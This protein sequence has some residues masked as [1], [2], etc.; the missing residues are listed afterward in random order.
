MPTDTLLARVQA[1]LEDLWSDPRAAAE[2]AE[3]PATSLAGHDLSESD[4]AN[5]NLQQ[6]AGN[7]SHSGNISSEGRGTLESFSHSHSSGHDRPVHDVAFVTREIHH[8]NPAVTNVFNDNR[9]FIDQSHDFNNSGI[10]AGDV[11][12]DDHSANAI[13]AG[14]VAGSGD[15]NVVAATGDGS[16]AAQGSTV[17][18]ADHGSQVIDGSTVGQNQSNS[19]G[20]VQ[21]GDEASGVNTGVNT[22]VV[23]GDQVD[24]TVVG[25][26]NKVA[27]VDGHADGSAIGFGQGDTSAAS[28]N[29]VRDGSLSSGGDA[30]SASHNEADHGGAIGGD[31]ALGHSLESNETNVL[32]S[33][34]TNLAQDESHATAHQD[35]HQVDHTI[36]DSVIHDAPVDA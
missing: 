4:L 12:I 35:I 14:A 13:G 17:N 36:H 18:Q 21:S 7:L 28:G 33:E 27:N 6:I 11:N 24:D 1:W 8:A 31:D 9:T 19:D 23:A 5:V 2:F 26:G 25:D 29:H 34:D 10:I 16:T 20:G 3:S 15:A 32:G 22:G 30:H